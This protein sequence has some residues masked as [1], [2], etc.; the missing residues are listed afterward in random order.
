VL[1]APEYLSPSSLT[2]YLQ[3]PLKYKFSRIDGLKEPATEHTILG[4]YVHSILENF[5]RL[6]A[7]LRTVETARSLSRQIWDDYAEG[8]SNV[9]HRDRDAI[10]KIRLF[11]WR[12]WYCVENLLKMESSQ[13]INFDGI[14]TEL[15]HSISGVKIKGFID[16]WSV[17]DNKIKIGD[18]KTGKVP[19]LRYREDKFD[20]LLIYGIILSEMQDMEI[21][22]LEL[23]YIKDG[24]RLTNKPKSEDIQKIKNLLV[25]T[26][27]AIDERC[28]SEVFETKVGVLCGWCHFKPICPAWS[29]NK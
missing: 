26:R 24:V 17:E 12:A 25:D 20:Q 14:E 8:V 16:R 3:C 10:E 18:Y 7:H 11:K 2:T 22:T 4:N 13:E 27:Q 23:L 15:N 5:Y 1:E 9:Y 28:Q 21:D 6:D 29:K 19:A